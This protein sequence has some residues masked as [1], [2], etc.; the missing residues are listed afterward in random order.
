MFID[1]AVLWGI[2][3]R[4]VVFTDVSGQRIGLILTGEESE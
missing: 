4:R 2:M 1:S 3:G